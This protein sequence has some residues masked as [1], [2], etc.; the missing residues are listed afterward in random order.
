MARVMHSCLYITTRARFFL[1]L[2][3]FLPE[4]TGGG[5]GVAMGDS[6]SVKTLIG[7]RE[8]EWATWGEGAGI[9]DRGG[10]GMGRVAPRKS[11]G[12]KPAA[13]ILRSNSSPTKICPGRALSSGEDHCPLEEA[14]PV[15]KRQESGSLR[16]GRV[17]H[18]RG[19]RESRQSQT[20]WP[21]HAPSGPTNPDRAG[22]Q[23]E[24]RVPLWGLIRCARYPG[25]PQEVRDRG[26]DLHRDGGSRGAASGG[27]PSSTSNL[28]RAYQGTPRETDEPGSGRTAR[29]KIPRNPCG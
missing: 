17:T 23:N 7:G 10:G 5:E 28:P 22:T 27:Q 9:G 25:A 16:L 3:R 24:H 8:G 18:H 13:I 21:H 19:I 11:L 2:P 20:E 15:G 6:S 4:G 12:G 1:L 29:T 26:E 14:S